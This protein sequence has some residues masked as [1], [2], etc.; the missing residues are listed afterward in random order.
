MST[1]NTISIEQALG[2][3]QAHWNAGQVNEAERL[4]QQVL[5]VWPAQSDALHLMGLMAHAYGNLDLAIDHLR[6]ACQSPRV[7]PIYLSNLAEMCR[8]RGLLAEGEEAGR[9]AVAGDNVL[10]AAWNNLGIIQQEAGKLED[11]LTSLE[12]VVVLQP[13]NPEAHNNLG[14]TLKRL[15][16]LDEARRHYERALEL[17]PAYAEAMSNLANLLNDLGKPDEALAFARRAIDTNPRIGD[18]YI[19]AAA[20]EMTRHRYGEALRW[21]DAMLAF[22]PLHAGALG[23]R[24]TA[25]RHLERFDEALADARRAVALAPE[26]GE[27]HNILGEVLQAMDRPDEALAAYDR[28]AATIG[29]APEKA[30][31]NRGVV[32]M[33]RGEKPAAAA[34]FEQVIVR[35]PRSVAAWFN[36]SDLHRFASGDPGIE[37][38]D[39]LARSPQIQSLPDRIALQFALGKA[40]LDAGD[41]ERAFAA[42]DAA[43]RLK[44]S[45]FEF[46]IAASERWLDQI[47]Q[48]FPQSLIDRPKQAVEGSEQVLF[49]VGMPRSGTTLVEQILGSHA[50]VQPAG[51]LSFLS[52]MM[53]QL[54]DYPALAQALTPELEAA[55]GARYLEL[56]RPVANQHRRV[57]DKMPSNFFYAGVIARIL[58]AAR[59]IHVRR[60][61][62][63]TCLSCYTKLFTREQLFTYDQAELGR[64]YRGYERLMAHWRAVLPAD[65]LL[66]VTYE[67][68]VADLEGQARRLIAFA[69]LDWDAACMEFNK[70][71]RT[72]RTASVNQAREPLFASSVGRWKPLA[73]Y[74]G[75][76]LAALG[77]DPSAPPAKAKSTRKPKASTV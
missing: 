5:A 27:A 44:R 29:F 72:I 1:Q 54:G 16:R 28:A 25:L 8:Q 46:D 14:N 75:P 24:A 52:S 12:R 59:I 71:R 40:R 60:D 50:A 17:V 49:V 70:T 19:N 68:V 42:F 22:A 21:I 26:S 41:P 48:A 51:E 73:P 35:Y 67:D 61:P 76:L 45:T 23:V 56:V 13:D 65:R 63:D 6:R 9:R 10:I 18:A 4:C 55:L 58:P 62:V 77:I 15:G 34:A 47:A 33:E 38:M 36:Y 64:F 57:V 43:N 53:G 30:M 20:V 3:A 32:L 2:Q 39:A 11:S 31:I 66:E 74:L 69:G 7:A 37:A